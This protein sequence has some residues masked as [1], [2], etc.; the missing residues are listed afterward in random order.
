[1]ALTV[2]TLNLFLYCYFGSH[3]TENCL[4]FANVLYKTEWYN[5]SVKMQ[6]YFVLM[7]ANAQKELCYSGFGIV[8]MN[9]ETFSTVFY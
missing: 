7:I 6:R 3:V 5:T 9:I 4:K 8:L 1:M 2:S